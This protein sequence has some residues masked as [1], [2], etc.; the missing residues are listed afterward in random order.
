MPGVRYYQKTSHKKNKKGSEIKAVVF[1]VEHV[2]KHLNVSVIHQIEKQFKLP[3][4]TLLNIAN[5]EH[6]WIKSLHVNQINLQTWK[7]KV[8][9]TL[10]VNFGLSE[11]A[12]TQV[13]TSG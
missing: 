10:K 13:T 8:K 4:N 5:A 7:H 1:E 3:H 9:Q 2:L 6:L 11:K 12:V